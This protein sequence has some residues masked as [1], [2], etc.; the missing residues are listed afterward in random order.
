MLTVNENK[1]ADIPFDFTKKF[2]SAV[3]ST[4]QRQQMI[5]VAVREWESAKNCKSVR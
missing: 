3:L 4:E 1:V 5:A 2:V